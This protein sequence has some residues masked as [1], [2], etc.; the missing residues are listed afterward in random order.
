MVRLA[1]RVA[2]AALA[3][4]L[5]VGGASAQDRRQNEPGQFDFYVLALS[6]SPSFCEASGERGTPPRQ[7]CGERPYSF[8]VHGLWPQYEKGFPE[9]C[10]QPP[11]RLD[12]NW[13]YNPAC[14]MARP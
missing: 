14:K 1:G 13:S 8:V 7:Q 11:P 2:V 5:T 3:L 4:V 6:W 12:R 9:Y 10:Q